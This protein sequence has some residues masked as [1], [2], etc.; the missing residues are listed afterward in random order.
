MQFRFQNRNLD[1]TIIL[2]TCTNKSGKGMS[3][4]KGR[5]P[6]VKAQFNKDLFIF[7]CVKVCRIH[8]LP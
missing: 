8:A 1:F 7:R 2:R 6:Q 3:A 5:E 4:S